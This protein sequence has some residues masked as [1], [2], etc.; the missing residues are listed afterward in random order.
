MKFSLGRS[1]SN[2]IVINDPSISLQH[3]SVDIKDHNIVVVSDEGSLN[4]LWVDNRRVQSAHISISNE[5]RVGNFMLDFSRIFKIDNGVIL[6]K[7]HPNDFTEYFEKLVLIE[8]EYEKKLD[9][10]NNGSSS[11]MLLF[12]ASMIAM[13]VCGLSRIVFASGE[14]AS[15][16][17]KIL[18]LIFAFIFGVSA[19]YFYSKSIKSGKSKE[20]DRRKIRDHYKIDFNCP[21][22]S[23]FIPDSTYVMTVKKQ[24]NCRYCKA[25]LFI[26]NQ[27]N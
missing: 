2:D 8:K 11:F 19:I 3:A 6:D 26:N 1:E 21:K 17:S 7:K 10:I 16:I 24:Y 9:E 4:G 12:R 20:K 25:L 27:N 18:P 22:C 5:V 13:S 23:N 15:M 14:D